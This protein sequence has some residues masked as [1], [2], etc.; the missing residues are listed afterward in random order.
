MLRSRSSP[1]Y[2]IGDR[3]SALL[4]DV[5]IALANMRVAIHAINARELK[6]GNCQIVI[7]VSIENLQHLQNIIGAMQKVN[8]V[9]SVERSAQ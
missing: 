1:P 2:D 4:A 9:I 5:T 7:T 8:G 6:G 3:P